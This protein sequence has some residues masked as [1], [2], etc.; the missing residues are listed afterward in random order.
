MR[1]WALAAALSLAACP[2]PAPEAGAD[3]GST[4]GLDAAATPGPDAA[5]P[6]D[7]GT[8]A[9]DS[10]AQAADAGG[11][12]PDA[13]A[14]QPDSGST[15]LGHG[16]RTHAPFPA[17]VLSPSGTAAAH[18]QATADFY[19]AWKSKYLKA[20]CKS[21]EYRVKSSPSTSAYT[22]SEAH[23]YGMIFAV[24]MAGHD[25]DARTIFDGLV[26]Y[27]DGHPSGIDS[28]LMAW[29]QDASCADV[30][31]NDAATDGDLDIA[32]AL[33]LADRQWG[34][35]GAVNYL[36]KGK[37]TIASILAS[38]IHP[39]NSILVGD[40]AGSSDSHYD[41][42]RPSDFA[43][44]H[45]KAFQKA[46]GVAR[47]SLVVDKTYSTI[48]YLQSQYAATTGLL[49]DFAVNAPTA[50][51]QPA[52]AQWLEGDDD[53][54]YSWNACRTP[55]RIAT[56]FVVSGEPRSQA[57]I[58]KL[59]AW[60]RTKTGGN[61]RS[62]RDGYDLSGN[63]LGTGEEL[64]FIAPFG[65]AAMVEAESGS[66]QAWLDALWTDVAGRST[67]DYYADSIKLMAMLVM[68]GNWWAP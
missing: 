1:T 21:G 6:A 57:A 15:G 45:F 38:E 68:G 16:F 24:V 58:R 40:W 10:G 13:A 29:A 51:P 33:L 49:P 2:G 55:W 42:T 63:A 3:S 62:I 5:T 32:Y 12:G 66:N 37:A 46:S 67:T 23:G 27:R 64:A 22:V 59:N 35:S 36:Q 4:P 19:D 18:D 31:G 65:V 39:Q 56:D 7:V 60:I 61:P 28:G 50:T 14:A 34:S 9:S 17:G 52:P 53:G 43:P 44:G 8:S 54:H 47:W 41:G 20:G 26:A 30:E 25:P 48:G 11:A